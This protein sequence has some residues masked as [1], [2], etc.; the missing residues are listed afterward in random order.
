IV[1]S[2]SASMMSLDVIS[3]V[4]LVFL[5]QVFHGRGEVALAQRAV[6]DAVESEAIEPGQLVL[7]L[8]VE[9]AHVAGPVGRLLLA[10][11]EERLLLGAIERKE[12][13]GESLWGEEERGR[14]PV[15]DDFQ[16]VTIGVSPEHLGDAPA[17]RGVVL[18]D[19]DRIAA[20]RGPPLDEAGQLQ[21]PGDGHD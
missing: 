10:V 13:E 17:G 11:P 14:D 7:L 3:T 18:D 19:E 15:V 1:S 9:D 8:D 16:L 5:K 4:S 21:A 2:K 20:G 12:G 6:E